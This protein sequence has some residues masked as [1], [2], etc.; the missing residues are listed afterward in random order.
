MTRAKAV[1]DGA[2]PDVKPIMAA[3][4]VT[5]TLGLFPSSQEN[6]TTVITLLFTSPGCPLPADPV[7]RTARRPCRALAAVIAPLGLLAC[8]LLAIGATLGLTTWLFQDIL[9]GD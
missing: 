3:A 5:N 2:Y 9:G 4:P 7:R 6:G 8:S 1:T